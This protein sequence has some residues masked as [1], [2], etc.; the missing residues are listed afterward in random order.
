MVIPQSRV[1]VRC[2][3]RFG[4]EVVHCHLGQRCD[5][6]RRT[7]GARRERRGRALRPMPI[8]SATETSETRTENVIMCQSLPKLE[9]HRDLDE[10]VDRGTQSP[11]GARSAI[12][13]RHRWRV[14]RDRSQGGAAVGRRRPCR[15][16]ARRSPSSTSPLIPA[17]AS[18]LGISRAW[19]RGAAKVA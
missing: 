18:I 19:L 14:D 3:F 2:G 15:H 10:R 7:A 4:Q 13:A 16:F 5:S 11:G 1:C 6:R 17:T 9:F 12:A 8:A